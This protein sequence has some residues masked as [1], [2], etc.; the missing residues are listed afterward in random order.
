[1]RT[2]EYK[3]F[4]SLTET[5]I[6]SGKIREYRETKVSYTWD[7]NEE[8]VHRYLQK[9]HPKLQQMLVEP[10]IN[11][12]SFGAWVLSNGNNIQ[13]K[14]KVCAGISHNDQFCEYLFITKMN[15]KFAL[16][17]IIAALE[18]LKTIRGKK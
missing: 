4:D 11:E 9:Y 17:Q 15:K 5:Q 2:T 8:L 6:G 12:P 18:L 13:F 3:R 14:T 7:K 10:S 1:M 16:T